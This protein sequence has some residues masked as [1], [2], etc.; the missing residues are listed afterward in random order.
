MTGNDLIT[1]SLKLLGAIGTGETPTAAEI[2]DGLSRLNSMLDSWNAERLMIFT[3]TRQVFSLTAG[4]QT[5]TVGSGGDFNVARPPRI[6]RISI[7]SLT[8]PAQPLELPM[9]QL[10]D[11]G[12]QNIPVKN[13]SSTLPLQV[14]D[15][16]AFPLRNLNYW[17]IPSAA[18]NTAL[19]Y[20]TQLSQFADLTTDYTFPPGYQQALEYG[21]AVHCAPMFGLTTPVEV[22]AIAITS[23]QKV[24]NFNAPIMYSRVD[25]ALVSPGGYYDWRSDTYVGGGRNS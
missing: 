14:Y 25:A 7:I 12:W 6:D 20:W 9:E 19:Y 22:A 15:D 2:A 24:E 18:V 8:N 3:I 17:P 5:Y 21:L 13:V 16:G 1:T 4:Q 23:K 10:T 11:V